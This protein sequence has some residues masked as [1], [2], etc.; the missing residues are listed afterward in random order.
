MTRTL[1]RDAVAALSVLLLSALPAAALPEDQT[2]FTNFEDVSPNT[3]P[4]EIIVVGISPD[5]ADLGGDAFGGRIGVRTLYHSGVR[6]WM[7]EANGTGV[8][9]FETEGDVVE[10]YARVLSSAAGETIIT[11][12]DAFDVI[13]DG[14]VTVEPG[15]GWQL[16]SLTGGIA[17]IDVVNLDGAQLN[18]IDD[19]GFTPLPEPGTA[20]TLAL[21]AALLLAIGRRRYAD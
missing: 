11:A 21:G 4:G 19:F 14:P 13:V 20:L 12:F 15:T 6:S 18:G 3:V 9:T 17:R 10:F 2:V 1:V 8:I 16:V 7:V 5:S